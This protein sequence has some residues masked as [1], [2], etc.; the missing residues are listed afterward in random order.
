MI[1]IKDKNDSVTEEMLRNSI[2]SYIYVP[3]NHF[4]GASEEDI[5]LWFGGQLVAYEV[6]KAFYDFTLNTFIDEESLVYSVILSDGAGFRLAEDSEIYIV[7]EDEFT[8]LLLSRSVN[9]S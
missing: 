6:L 5:N 8:E 2:G 1:L 3:E 7:T 4:K 9:D